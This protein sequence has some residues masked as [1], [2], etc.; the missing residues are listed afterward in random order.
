MED[1]ARH[2]TVHVRGVY[3]S[4]RPHDS[5]TSPTAR[6][7]ANPKD[8][9]WKVT[10]L[11]INRAVS[12]I[13]SKTA[14]GLDGITVGLV[15]CLGERVWEH[16]AT[17]YTGIIQADPIPADWLQS[18]VCLVPKPGGDASFLSDHRPITLTSIMYRVFA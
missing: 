5:P 7:T 8:S 9:L 3:D 10:R 6:R 11:A 12:K 1:I 13:S 15:K 2:L 14:K 16:L 17:I 4:T 18:R